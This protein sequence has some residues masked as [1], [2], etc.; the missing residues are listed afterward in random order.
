MWLCLTRTPTLSPGGDN[1]QRVTIESTV[2]KKEAAG[3]QQ[4]LFEL[5]TQ[6]CAQIK[7]ERRAKL[8]CEETWNNLVLRELHNMFELSLVSSTTAR[9]HQE[10]C[11]IAGPVGF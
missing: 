5:A 7:L 11:R 6:C 2:G 9:E 3:Q 10:S 8:N 4:H 1:P